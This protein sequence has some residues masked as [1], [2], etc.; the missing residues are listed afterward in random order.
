MLRFIF[1]G[2]EAERSKTVDLQFRA[3]VTA[4]LLDAAAPISDENVWRI[5]YIAVKLASMVSIIHD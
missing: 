5:G 1:S 3:V 4:R 2:A